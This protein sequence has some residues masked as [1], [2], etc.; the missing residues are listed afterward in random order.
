MFGYRFAQSLAGG[1]RTT[2]SSTLRDMTAG[3]TPAPPRCANWPSALFIRRP[4]RSSRQQDA[5]RVRYLTRTL[6]GP[7]DEAWR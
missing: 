1:M 7:R 4:R 2:S 3:W 5:A 6:N